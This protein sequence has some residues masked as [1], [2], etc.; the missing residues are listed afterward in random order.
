MKTKITALKL[1]IE[2]NL[3]TFIQVIQSAIYPWKEDN[4]KFIV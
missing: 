4:V 1:L 2:S 3:K